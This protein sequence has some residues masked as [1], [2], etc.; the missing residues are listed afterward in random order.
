MID[1]FEF[2][3]KYNVDRKTIVKRIQNV[4]RINR[5]IREKN[6]NL[7]TDEQENIKRK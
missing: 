5:Y 2:K 4:R 6:I 7:N 3:E 1:N